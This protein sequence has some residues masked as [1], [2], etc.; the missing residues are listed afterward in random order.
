MTQATDT[1]IR[2]LILG[3][4]KK[5]DALDK[6]VEINSARTDERFNAIDQ[7]F[8]ALETDISDIKTDLRDIRS[9]DIAAMKTELRDIRSEVKGQDARLWGF[10]IAL[11]LSL[12]GVLAKVVFFP[13][14]QL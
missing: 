4:E 7:R 3:L 11:F 13:G 5:L 12:A 2:D 10:V 6:K 1:E 14:G 8:N 9:T